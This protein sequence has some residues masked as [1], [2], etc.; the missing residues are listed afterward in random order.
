[1][2]SKKTH[3]RSILVIY[4]MYCAP[5]VRP[6]DGSCFSFE[7]L[8]KLS[9]GWNRGRSSKITLNGDKRQLWRQL[10]QKLSNVCDNEWCW[11]EQP[12]AREI[13]DEE[14]H[15]RTF[16][17]L[18]PKGEYQWLSTDDIGQI[19][20]QYEV[21]YPDFVFFGPAPID[22]RK[23]H[24]EIRDISFTDLWRQGKHRIGFVFNLDPSDQPGSHWVALY[25][26]L[27]IPEVSF[28]DSYASDP[29]K[30]IA[31]FM[32][33]AATMLSKGGRKP[34]IQVNRVRHQ[35]LNTECGVF[36]V[37]YLIERLSGKSFNEV[38]RNTARD[39]Q[40]HANRKVFFRPRGR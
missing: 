32:D 10:R 26:D 30:E 16:R 33:Y 20:R 35:Y 19:M 39:E 23:V 21:L 2:A 18:R 37:N 6:N 8:Q 24:P 29:P 3:R 36:S 9:E 38:T 7:S 25:I 5:G 15:R 14:I 27:R 17:P 13:Q 34:T 40:M 28:Y 1:M 31:E 11:I 4:R 12:F 22:F